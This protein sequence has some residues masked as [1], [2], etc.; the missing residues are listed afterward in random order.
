MGPLPH[1]MNNKFVSHWN[2]RTKALPY[3]F[4]I[5]SV[6]GWLP[7][8]HLPSA[9]IVAAGS[10]GIY[11]GAKPPSYAFFLVRFFDARQKNEQQTF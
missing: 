3:R 5:L 10:G 4:D 7:I 1:M 2:G 6:D 11:K 9:R 8:S